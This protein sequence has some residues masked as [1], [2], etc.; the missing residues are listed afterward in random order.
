MKLL[1][2]QLPVLDV[3]DGQDLLDLVTRVPGVVAALVDEPAAT[4]SVAVSSD[5]SAL[6]VRGQ[7]E[8]ALLLRAPPVS[9]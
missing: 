4:L 8:D 6:L 1:R 7:V 2:F 9:A 5:A 3:D